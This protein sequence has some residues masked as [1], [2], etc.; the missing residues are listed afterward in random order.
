MRAAG[1]EALVSAEDVSMM[2]VAEVVP[3]LPR[4]LDAMDALRDAAA[5]GARAPRS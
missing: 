5:I 2:G 1:F 4:I 3:A